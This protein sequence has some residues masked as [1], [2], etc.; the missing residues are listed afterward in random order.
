MY[1]LVNQFLMMEKFMS[2]Y[3]G[4]HEKETLVEKLT[5]CKGSDSL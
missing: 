1:N 3:P 5:S 4:L 2:P